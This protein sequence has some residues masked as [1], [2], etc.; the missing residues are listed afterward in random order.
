MKGFF[1]DDILLK[2]ESAALLYKEVKDLPIID[3][4]CHLN[5]DLI[6]SDA[7]VGDIGTLWLGGDHYKWRAM[8][9]CG[10][11]EYYIT[12][13]ASWKEKFEKYAEIVPQLIG[14]PLYY[15]THLELQQ[16]FGIYE[17]LNK[18]TA[19]K[20]FDE[21]NKKLQSVTVRGL[22]KKFK[23]QFVATTND[24]TETL[25]SHGAYDGIAVSPTF[26]PDK[27]YSLDPAYIADLGKAAGAEIKTLADLK[28]ALC[29]RIDF[30]ASKGC[31]ISDHGFADFPAAYATESEMEG[32]FARRGSLNAAEKD[33]AFGYLLLFLMGEYKKRNIVV[34]LHFSVTRN[35]NSPMFK[36]LGAD[37]GF[38]VIGKEPDLENVMRFL[39]KMPD[40]ERPTIILYTLNPN[41]VAPLACISGAFR[42]VYM[43]AAWWFNDTVNGISRNLDWISEYACLG[44]NLGMLTDSRSFSSYSRFDFFRR[45]LCTFVGKKVDKGEYPLEDAKTLVK[46]ISYYNI[47]NL[48]KL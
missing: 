22:L 47:K 16:V 8:R 42:G 17:P 6:A 40:E 26:R 12:G 44:T 9:M 14:N 48:L 33:A 28:Q 3:Y 32:L 36:K 1:A 27:L 13:G 41:A 46:N 43:G 20:I 38:D 34:Q 19:D 30:F 18:D 45:I 23:V 5:Q 25:A 10:V 35:I 29:A 39:D 11:D 21:A 15:W 4:H 24:P 7:P 31:R 2:G 37:A